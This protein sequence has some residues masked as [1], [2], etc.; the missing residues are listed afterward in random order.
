MM[1]FILYWHLAKNN[2]NPTVYKQWNK[3]TQLNA[4]PQM[5]LISF[6]WFELHKYFIFTVLYLSHWTFLHVALY[7]QEYT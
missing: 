3:K 6:D 1:P 2:S 5:F 4:I 7:L